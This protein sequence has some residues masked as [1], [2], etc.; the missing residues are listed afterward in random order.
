VLHVKQEVKS[1]S[2]TVLQ[3]VLESDIERTNLLTKNVELQ[4]KMKQVDST[5][6]VEM[7]N[8]MNEMNEVHER[9]VLIGFYFVF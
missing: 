1:S 5:N 9:M 4:E 7:Q 6:V 8:I 3:V 2:K